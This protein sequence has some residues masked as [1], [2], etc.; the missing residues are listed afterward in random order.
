M[1]VEELAI[2]ARKATTLFK[3]VLEPKYDLLIQSLK[4]ARENPSAEVTAQID[5]ARTELYAGHQGFAQEL[6]HAEALILDRF[7]AGS[8]F[9]LQAVD[10]ME[11]AFE[12][13]RAD[14]A[15]AS[16]EIVKIK[17]QTQAVVQR[18]S[19]FLESLGPIAEAQLESARSDSVVLL[20]FDDEADIRDLLQLEK[21]A[22]KWQDVFRAFYRL[23]GESPES[24]KIVS[25]GHGSLLLWLELSTA[26]VKLLAVVSTKVVEFLQKYEKLRNAQLELIQ[27]GI[28]DSAA[29]ALDEDAAKQ[30]E[31]FAETVADDLYRESPVTEN[32][33]GPEIRNAV[34]VSIEHLTVHVEEGGYLELP[35]GNIENATQ[36]LRAFSPAYKEI[37]QLKAQ[38][39]ELK[40]LPAG[41][42]SST[43]ADDQDQAR[44]GEPSPPPVGQGTSNAT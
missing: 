35:I 9:G 21:A 31:T 38:L 17:K 22:A 12:A 32:N 11:N 30:R 25:A 23:A 7:E 2:L 3:A 29:Q 20:A 15:G 44:L 13:F 28:G 19:Q 16:T 36:P 26:V 42:K 40:Q 27:L 33:D 1:T 41:K 34:Q 5:T 10:R 39:R 8:L 14:P 37:R 4:A 24:P 18:F 43:G 6:L